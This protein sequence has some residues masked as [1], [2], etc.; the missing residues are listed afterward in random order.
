MTLAFIIAG[1]VATWIRT[2]AIAILATVLFWIFLAALL[3]DAAKRRAFRQPKRLEL[4]D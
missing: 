2:L 4:E 3:A 1:K